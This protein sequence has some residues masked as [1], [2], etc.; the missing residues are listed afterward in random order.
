M[1]R[2]C[3]LLRLVGCGVLLVAVT[4]DVPHISVMKM[5]V[6]NDIY[7]SLLRAFRVICCMR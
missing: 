3:F 7:I 1:H 6:I 4:V 5:R 2:T